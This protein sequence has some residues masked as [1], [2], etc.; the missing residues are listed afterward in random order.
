MNYSSISDVDFTKTLYVDKIRS[1]MFCFLQLS[2][3]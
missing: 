3:E 2:L 1:V